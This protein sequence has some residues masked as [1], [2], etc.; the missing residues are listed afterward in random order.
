MGTME[1]S[2]RPRLQIAGGCHCPGT[3]PPLLFRSPSRLWRLPEVMG[4]GILPGLAACA[5][6][7]PPVYRFT[8]CV[9]DEAVPCLGWASWGLCPLVGQAGLSRR[10]EHTRP[11]PSSGSWSRGKSRLSDRLLRNLRA[12]CCVPTVCPGKRTSHHEH[13]QTH[14]Q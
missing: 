14:W 9:K 1:N 6:P 3:A 2:P 5:I 8:H 10:G 7:A 11:T 4:S 12:Q 13:T